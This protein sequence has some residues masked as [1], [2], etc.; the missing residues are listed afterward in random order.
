MNAYRDDLEA[1]QLRADGLEREL[2]QLRARNAE[3][4][5]QRADIKRHL[6]AEHEAELEQQRADIKRRMLAEHEARLLVEPAPKPLPTTPGNGRLVAAI[7]GWLVAVVCAA[8]FS[9]SWAAV[10]VSV[11]FLVG[12][13][14]TSSTSTGQKD[15][16]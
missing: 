12:M 13:A 6:L 3:L 5:Q 8:Q 10:L 16:E 1:A 9:A 2:Q 11:A 15:R 7:G 14:M 4:E